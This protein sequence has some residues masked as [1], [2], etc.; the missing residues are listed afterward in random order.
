MGLQL[1][2]TCLEGERHTLKESL[3]LTR[4][5]FLW[6]LSEVWATLNSGWIKPM[7]LCR[8]KHWLCVKSLCNIPCTEFKDK[9]SLLAMEGWVVTQM[10]SWLTWVTTQP[11]KL[12]HSVGFFHSWSGFLHLSIVIGAW[13]KAS[14][15]SRQEEPAVVAWACF[16][17]LYGL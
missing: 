11:T 3:A 9:C 5:I 7:N 1:E 8:N 4:I 2:R 12:W 15:P 16:G 17:R 10:K 6:G 14:A 13:S